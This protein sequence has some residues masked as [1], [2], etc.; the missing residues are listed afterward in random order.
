MHTAYDH[1]V[2]LFWY[3]ISVQAG[4]ILHQVMFLKNVAQIEIMQI[5]N[6]LPI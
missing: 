4:L 2:H 1:I 3:I 5:N 6:K